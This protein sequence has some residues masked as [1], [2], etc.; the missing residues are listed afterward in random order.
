MYVVYKIVITGSTDVYRIYVS[1]D[2]GKT[3]NLVFTSPTRSFIDTTIVNISNDGQNI[4]QYERSTSTV[5]AMT[6]SN[7]GGVTFTTRISNITMTFGNSHAMSGTGQ[8]IAFLVNDNG[9]TGNVYVST[10]Y[11][12]SW[13]TT[14]FGTGAGGGLNNYPYHISMSDSGQYIAL[15]TASSPGRFFMS[16]NYGST[17]VQVATIASSYGTET[18]LNSTGTYV[19]FGASFNAFNVTYSTDSGAN[20]SSVIRNSVT[21]DMQQLSGTRGQTWLVPGKTTDRIMYIKKTSN[22]LN[23]ATTVYTDPVAEYTSLT[24]VSMLYA[25]SDGKC[26]LIRGTRGGVADIY[27]IRTD[28]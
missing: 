26:I 25:S 20:F 11:G 14:A 4:I 13:T 21:E 5:R 24:A 22:V 9:A 1:S 28:L 12:E 8:Y 16:S 27:V 6:V 19:A 15:A 17:W 23:S 18:F 10:N 7:D 3:S 2:S